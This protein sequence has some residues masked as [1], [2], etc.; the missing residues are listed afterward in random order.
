MKFPSLGLGSLLHQPTDDER[1]ADAYRALMHWTAEVGGN[2]FGT[3]PKGT[4]R[5]FFCLDPNTWVWHE[6]WSDSDGR[7]T[8]TTRYDVR[9]SG[10]VK[11]QGNNVYQLVNHEEARNLYSAI[12][13]Y[14]DRV[15]PELDRLRRAGNNG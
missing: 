6:E 11:S 14:R 12:Q 1:R 9:P 10:I 7:H 3:V 8:M 13:L 15:L 5:E 4:R 2:L